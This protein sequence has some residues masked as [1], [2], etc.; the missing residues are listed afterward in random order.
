LG[1]CRHRTQ[2]RPSDIWLIVSEIFC[3][4][5]RAFPAFNKL[6]LLLWKKNPTE[7][8]RSRGNLVI[9]LTK[10]RTGGFGFRISVRTEQL[11]GLP[12]L[13][14][15]HHCSFP[16][17]KRPVREVNHSPAYSATDMNYLSYAASAPR[18][19]LRCMDHLPFNTEQIFSL[20]LK[21]VRT[22]AM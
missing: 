17:L 15:G 19:S 4:Y 12:N 9:I 8:V 16:W 10:L 11:W 1:W 22:H 14:N 3:R 20:Y 21:T 13:F 2:L 5:T 6:R 18:I 7:Q